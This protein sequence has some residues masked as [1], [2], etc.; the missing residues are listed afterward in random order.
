MD[1]TTLKDYSVWF[2]TGSQHLYGPEALKQVAEDSKRIVESL[3]SGGK[4]PTRIIARQTV[5][6]KDEITRTL[7]EASAEETCIGV[8]AW[9]HTFSPAKM[10][11]SGL[12]QL[13]KPLLQ[14]HTQL[15]SGIPWD[16]IDMDYMNLHQTA[17]GGR[18]FGFIGSRLR[19]ERK[20]VV[21]H[22]GDSDVLARIDAWMRAAGAFADSRALKVARIGDNMR[23][24]AVTEGDKVEAERVFGYSVNGYGVGDLV[25]YVNAV[26]DHETERLIDEYRSSYRIGDG[27]EDGEGARRLRAAAK[28]EIGLRAFLAEGGFKAFTTTFEDLHGLEQLPGIAVQ[29]LMAAGIGFGPEGDWKTAALVRAM[30]VMGAGLPAGTTL[31]EDYTYHFDAERS[32]VLGAHMLEIC[33]SVSGGEISIGVHPLG[34]GGKDDPVRLV[35]DGAPGPAVNVSV[36]DVGARFRMVLNE[37]EAIDPP[38]NLPCLPVARVVWDPIPDLATAAAAWIYAGGAHHTGYSQAVNAEHVTDFA[39]MAGVELIRIDAS[40]TVESVKNELRWNELY[41]HVKSGI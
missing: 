10:W 37:V 40:S 9:M 2:V 32:L 23:Q 35:F 21:G 7:R 14:L 39:S 28:I 18:E 1:R 33:P 6:T 29:R 4:M 20:V 19:M 24:V 41:Y 17:H 13:T 22:W 34:I 38:K 16:S 27:I 12:S 15:R 26:S 30:K 3:N 5:T 31:M 25:A 8:I 11:I 36:I